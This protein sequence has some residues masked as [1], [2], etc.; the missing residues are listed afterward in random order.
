MSRANIWLVIFFFNL[1]L[2]GILFSSFRIILKIS[3]EARTFPNLNF[4]FVLILTM[5]GVSVS[6]GS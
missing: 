2:F 4:L 1:L 3:M 5:F 6:C